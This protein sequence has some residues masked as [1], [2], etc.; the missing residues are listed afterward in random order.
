MA[1]HQR[2]EKLSYEPVNAHI[3]ASLG[4]GESTKNKLKKIIKKSDEVPL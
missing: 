2:G 4:L 3:F 1:W